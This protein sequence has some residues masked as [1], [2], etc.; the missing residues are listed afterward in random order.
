MSNTGNIIVD[1]K[2]LRD[3]LLAFNQL[4]NT[5]LQNGLCT[6]DLA[7]LIELALERSANSELTPI[8]VCVAS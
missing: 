4:R 6:Y 3:C 8:W 2:L 1:E 5:K 7:E